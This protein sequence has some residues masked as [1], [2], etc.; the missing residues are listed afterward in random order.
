[1]SQNAAK[2]KVCGSCCPIPG[3]TP[4]NRNLIFFHPRLIYVWDEKYHV[5]PKLAEK[6][7]VE[8]IR[9]LRFGPNLPTQQIKLIPKNSG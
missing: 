8:N 2:T 5:Y 3:E 9:Y 7:D 4:E 6:S 1:M